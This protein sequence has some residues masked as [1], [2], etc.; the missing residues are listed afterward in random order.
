MNGTI[1]ET[2]IDVFCRVLEQVAFA[3]GEETPKEELP[4]AEFSGYL[5]C[6]I[7]FRGPFEG[8]IEMALPS[9]LCREL[10]ANTLGAERESVAPEM[11]AD[12]LKEIAN[13]TCGQW[14]TNVAGEKLVFD[15]SV[16][17][18]EDLGSAGWKELRSRASSIAMVV[19]DA[20]VL[21]DISVQGDIPSD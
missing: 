10:A 18:I 6:G 3:F 4:A 5:L 11:A 16:P 20:P 13:V 12:A 1:R 17:T 15:L 9:E 21:I 14:L 2:L 8:A 19:D 7:A